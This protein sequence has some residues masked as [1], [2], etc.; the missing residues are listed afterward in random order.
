VV[1]SQY[2]SSSKPRITKDA[3]GLEFNNREALAQLRSGEVN[4]VLYG[5]QGD[6]ANSIVLLS[7]GTG[8]VEELSDHLRDDVVGY[9]LVRLIERVDESDTVKF[10]FINW[11]GDN[12]PRML[13]ARIGTHSGAGCMQPYHV[14]INA[15][16]RNEVTE[17][18]VRSKV[19][20]AAGT[21]VHVVDKPSGGNTTT[22]S[23][24]SSSRRSSAPTPTKV[25]TVPTQNQ[26]IRILGCSELVWEPTVEQ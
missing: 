12:I 16:S 6:N 1:T 10:A 4:W 21:A 25:A 7:Q 18:I 14:D 26:G 13:R 5:Y 24:S 20:K 3:G 17:D 11:T 22:S 8:G 19:Q 23:S 15:S 2:A 9:A